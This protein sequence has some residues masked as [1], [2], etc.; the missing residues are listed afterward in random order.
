MPRLHQQTGTADRGET[1]L[2]FWQTC[3]SYLFPHDA[4]PNRPDTPCDLKERLECCSIVLTAHCCKPSG[5][6]RTK[7][8]PDR[9]VAFE[10][11]SRLHAKSVWQS[12][13]KKSYSVRIFFTPQTWN[14]LCTFHAILSTIFFHTPNVEQS[15]Y[16]PRD[17]FVSEQNDEST[18]PGCVRDDTSSAQGRTIRVG[19]V[20]RRDTGNRGRE[21]GNPSPSS[22]GAGAR[23]VRVEVQRGAREFR[24]LP[25]RASPAVVV[26]V[27]CCCCCCETPSVVGNR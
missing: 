17:T 4:P 5:I 11:V 1:W 22:G 9:G 10:V 26:V 15:M 12:F 24:L 8:L 13:R 16:I 2:I 23:S 18:L 3:E 19:E 20:A 14:S 21:A 7:F 6:S 25:V 27:G